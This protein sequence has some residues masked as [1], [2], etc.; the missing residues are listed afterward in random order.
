MQYQKK[1]KKLD[2]NKIKN[3]ISIV[4]IISNYIELKRKG[5][6]YVGLC[7]FHDDKH[8]S[9]VV[10]ESKKIYKCFS[11]NNSGDVFTFVKNFMHVNYYEAINKVSQLAGIETDELSSY[12]EN[13]KDLDV[14]YRINKEACEYFTMFLDN[15]ENK[16]VKDYLLSRDINQELIDKFEIGFSPNDPTIMIELLNNKDDIVRGKK[17]FQI[18]D[19]EDAGLAYVDNDG[20]HIS[21]FRNRIIFPI[22]NEYDEILGFSGR[23]YDQTEPKYLNTPSTKIFKKNEIFFNLNNV[24]KNY[25]IETIYLVE[26]FMDVISLYKLGINNA[27]AT[28]GVAFSKN[29]LETLAKLPNLKSVII[30]FDNDQAGLESI[31]KT[32]LIIKEKY[33]VYVVNYGDTKFKDIDEIYMHDKEQAL[34]IT[35]GI[36]DYNTYLIN[37]LLKQTP[38]NNQVDRDNLLNKLIDIIKQEKSEIIKLNNIKNVANKLSIDYELI[39]ELVSSNQALNKTS[40]KIKNNNRFEIKDI[41]LK[42][43]SKNKIWNNNTNKL[44]TIN[45]E[46]QI[47][48]FCI[49][50]RNW[51]THFMHYCGKVLDPFNKKLLLSIENYYKNNLDDESIGIEKLANHF[52][53]EKELNYIASCILEIKTKKIEYT[54]GKVNQVIKTHEMNLKKYDKEIIYKK[55]GEKPSNW[56]DIVNLNKKIN[57]K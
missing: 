53:D 29:H 55:L 22:K 41:E 18:K 36:V 46:K 44:P 8:A 49:S 15:K 32:A 25:D 13:R 33:N 5:N 20:N 3:K 37:K 31:D 57:N 10:N 40:I 14:L 39:K 38:I 12:I 19:I 9:L 42:N 48:N 2:L 50:N 52:K 47:I 7:P 35:N 54:R 27:V 21:Y 51:F 30:C 4:D 26:G 1:N 24:I 45:T 11:C 16:N 28:M 23:V 17:G 34:Q 43:S 6:N 56:Q